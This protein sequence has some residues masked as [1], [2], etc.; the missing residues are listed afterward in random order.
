M[1]CEHVSSLTLFIW[2]EKMTT[3]TVHCVRESEEVKS[4][5]L[6]LSPSCKVICTLTRYFILLNL[7]LLHAVTHQWK[8]CTRRVTA[9]HPSYVM[10]LCV[11]RITV[12]WNISHWK[13]VSVHELTWH[14]Q[15]QVNQWT[16]I[17][18]HS[19]ITN[20]CPIFNFIDIIR[21]NHPSSRTVSRIN[22]TVAVA[23]T[24]QVNRV[25]LL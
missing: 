2:S 7:S 6:S 16:V 25:H 14:S 18:I 24:F 3:L 4:L 15:W 17:R 11:I 21:M 12:Y 8:Q 23:V 19:V 20:C 13:S 9:R 1:H 10:S 5:S 22:R